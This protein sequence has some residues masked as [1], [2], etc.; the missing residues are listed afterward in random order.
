[1]KRSR[2]KRYHNDPHKALHLL[3]AMILSRRARKGWWLCAE[4]RHRRRMLRRKRLRELDW[5][6]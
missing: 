4:A 3:L 6:K 2:N 1:M 5:R